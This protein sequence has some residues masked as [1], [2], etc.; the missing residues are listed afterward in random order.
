MY[1]VSNRILFSSK[2]QII[3]VKFAHVNIV[4]HALNEVM[5]FVRVNIENVR[6]CCAR[7]IYRSWS[8]LARAN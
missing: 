5:M 6:T 2:I 1:F 8:S 3:Y 7:E 4:V